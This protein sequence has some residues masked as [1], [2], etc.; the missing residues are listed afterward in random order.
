VLDHDSLSS[1]YSY[2]M[3]FVIKFKC[4]LIFMMNKS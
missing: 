4:L 1:D 2:F 3:V